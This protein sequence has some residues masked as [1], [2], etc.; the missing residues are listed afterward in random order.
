MGKY[1]R[2]LI[3]L[4][5]LFYCTL[6]FGFVVSDIRVE[7]LQRVSAGTVFGAVPY[8]VGD[9]VGAEEIRTIARSLFQTET[10]DD[11]QIGRDG[12]VLVIVVKERPT[13]DSIEFE[14]NKAIK[15]EAL[16]E[17][18]EGSGLSEGQIFKKVT[19][20]QIASDLERQYVSQGRYDAN[21]ETTIENL[22]RNRVAI[23]VDVYEGNVS[24]I[25]HINIVG[26]TVFDDESL[27][28]LLELKL[29]GWL[30]FYTKD[31]QYSRE[32]LQSD[33]EVL[34]SHY[35]DRGYLTFRVD[36]TQVS[37]APNMEDVYIT[38]NVIEGDQFKISAVEVAGELRDIPEE[39][40]RALLLT[41]E[42]QTFSRQYMTLSEERIESALGNAGY[43]FA[44]ATGEPS[45]NDDGET[46]TV[47][48]FIDAG[49]RAYVRRLSFQGNTVTQDHVLRREMRQM[50][51]GW[52]STAMIEG[53]KI[54]LQRLGFFKEVNVETPTVPGTD[55]QIDVN[56]T[57]EEQPSGSISATVGYAQRMGLILGLGYQESNVFGTGNS[58][59]IGINRSDYQQSLNVSFFDPYYTVDGVSRG[60]SAF[61]RKSDYE[62]RNIASFS[63]D[64]Y[65]LNVS[66]GYPI[67]E[68]SRI[69]LTVGIERTEIKE[70]V[71]PAQEISEFLD[72]E[73]NEFDLVSLTATYSMSAL[74]RGLLPTGGRSQSMSFEMTVPGSELEYYRLNYT[75]QVFYPL[76]NP[77]VLRLRANLGYGEAYGGTENFPFYKHFFAGGMGSVRGYESNSLGPRSTPS[78]QD[79]FN[80][81]DPIGGNVLVELSA[82]VLFPLPFIE[83]QSQLKSV[84]FFDAGNVFNT[85]CPDVSVYCLGLDNGELRYSA[86]I[87]VT[88]ITGFAP[89]SFALAFPVNDKEGDESES[90]QFELGKTF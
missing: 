60:Y 71:I 89:I 43:T 3:P 70:G 5:T 53:S 67:S 80:D 65:G 22:P 54:R 17:G 81:P 10:F 8:S 82:E 85:N 29:P 59:N 41:R 20:D 14:G 50:E 11:V 66:F 30:S 42:G 74:N 77:F 88:W 62:E 73:G 23:K 51:G 34:E 24:G 72:E 55:D 9:N 13:I 87:A 6:S 83:D 12:N 64:S 68:I 21:I 25:R 47:K 52:A 48:Y 19:L 37:I 27:I 75:G 57:V 15:T 79:R 78:P 16:V 40:I 2:S 69:G 61:F 90:F 35:L 28:E 36:S 4:V 84:L 56:Y 38:I 76:F 1:A 26:N 58:I 49:K 7:G 86:G 31:D 44:S 33:I 46:V 39:N 63:T 45:A 32:K 18:L